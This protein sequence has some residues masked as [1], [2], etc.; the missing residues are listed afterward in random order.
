MTKIG[1]LIG[2]GKSERYFFPNLLV[3]KGYADLALKSPANGFY[4]KDDTYW[5]FPF[6]PGATKI[7]N[8]EGKTRLHSHETYREAY[9]MLENMAKALGLEEPFEVHL[10]VFFDTEGGDFNGCKTDIENAIDHCKMPFAT[11]HLQEV[12]PEIEGW[13]AAGLTEA[14]PHFHKALTAEDIRKFLY[15]EKSKGHPKEVFE[16][17]VDHSTLIGAQDVAVVVV[18]HFDE[19]K[20]CE[21]SSTFNC[22]RSKLIE[23]GLY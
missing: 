15:P 9:Y 20:A 2:E 5:F 16:R 1:L 18:E 22:L 3:K 12:E 6:P 19:E 14:F 10:I 7:N 23:L 11:K 21:N 13:Y 4:S 17:T 8:Q